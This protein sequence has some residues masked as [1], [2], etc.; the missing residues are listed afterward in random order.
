MVCLSAAYRVHSA[1]FETC[2]C[3][4]ALSL[5]AA[6]LKDFGR[7]RESGKNCET[8]VPSSDLFVFQFA[9]MEVAVGP[10]VGMKSS[11]IFFDSCPKIGHSSFYL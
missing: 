2:V 3:E 9:M 8:H 7:E 5:I 10:D 11:P 4:F 1:S 6:K